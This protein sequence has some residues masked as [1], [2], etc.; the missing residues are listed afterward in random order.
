MTISVTSSN[1]VHSFF[2]LRKGSL[3]NNIDL[4]GF[5]SYPAFEKVEN[6][7]GEIECVWVYLILP[8]LVLPE[9]KCTALFRPKAMVASTPNSKKIVRYDNF[10]FGVDLFPKVGW[11]EPI[12]MYPYESIKNLT[13]EQVVER[14]A[15]LLQK[16][17]EQTENFRATG[18]L[19]DGFSKS[20]LEISHPV[21]LSYLE[22]LTPN[23]VKSLEVDNH[24]Q[25]IKH[26]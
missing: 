22:H 12:A 1:D 24:I 11:H 23:F 17:D 14:E 25:K 19:S 16:C 9:Q 21:F 3:E 26:D 5:W 13:R 4:T 7:R 15:I 8:T 10:R 6:G 2:E 18:K 20:W